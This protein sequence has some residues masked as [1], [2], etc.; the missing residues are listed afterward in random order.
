MMIGAHIFPRFL[1]GQWNDNGYRRWVVG[2]NPPVPG[3]GIDS[4]RNG[5]MLRADIHIAFDNYLFVINPDV[6][7]SVLLFCDVLTWLLLSVYGYLMEY[8]TYFPAHFRMAI[9]SR[10]LLSIP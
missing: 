9:R 8:S 1:E 3:S 5:F 10:I 6:S 4:V 2:E 7:H